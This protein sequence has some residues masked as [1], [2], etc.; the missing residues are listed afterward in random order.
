MEVRLLLLLALLCLHAPRWALAQQPE[1]EATVIVKGSTKIAGMDPSYVC[2]TMDWMIYS[3]KQG[4]ASNFKFFF[5]AIADLLEVFK[6]SRHN[7]C[8]MFRYFCSRS[9]IA[10]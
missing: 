8:Q 9:L 6:F 7:L 1:E 2:A 5:H 10:A 3:R 4:E